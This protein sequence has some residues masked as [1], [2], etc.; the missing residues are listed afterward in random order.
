MK[1]SN[2][3]E[4]TT[5][6]YV[7][8]FYALVQQLIAA[9]SEY[10]ELLLEIKGFKE[11]N[12]EI[13]LDEEQQQQLKNINR[14]L[15]KAINQIQIHYETFNY[16]NKND[17]IMNKYSELNKKYLLNTETLKDYIIEINKYTIDKIAPHISQQS[18]MNNIY[19]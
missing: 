16:K 12:P 3:Q 10:E 13:N 7:I 17:K 14:F 2:E 6:N 9:Y 4:K 11:E 1:E 19:N 18:D 5:Q 8:N 15:R